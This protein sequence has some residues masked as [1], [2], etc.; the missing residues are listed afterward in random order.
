MATATLSNGLRI[1]FEPSTS[2][3]T[4]CGYLV[5]AGTRHEESADAGMAHFLEHMTFKGTARRTSLQINNFLERVGG[6]LNAFTNKQETVYHATVLRRD[7][8]RAIALLTDIVFHSTYPQSEITR[9]VEVIVDEIDS[10]RD[11]PAELIFDE[12]EQM[13]FA[14]HPLG[15]DILGTPERLRQYTTADATRFAHRFYRPDN[16]IFYIYGQVDFAR[17][18]RLLQKAHGATLVSQADMPDGDSFVRTPHLGEIQPLAAPT[19]LHRVVEKGT[20]Q[21]HVML[22]ARTFGSNDPR[23]FAL[24]L[25]NNML[26]GPGANSRLNTVVRERHG[27]VY[28]IDS[29]LNAYPDFGYWNAYFGCDAADVARCLRLVK[30]EL[31]RFVE[32][33]LS[34]AQ[35]RA[36]KAQLC[37]QIGISSDN[38]ESYA[39]GL[40]KTFAHFG[41]H[42]NISALLEAFN[43]VT[44]EEIQQL[45]AE[46]YDPE[47]LCT[48]IYK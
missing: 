37:G 19:A 24:S 40:G 8:A 15:R 23:R 7:V 38:K 21:A 12:F 9:E 34:A 32:R 11:S 33:P 26:G 36:A 5:C 20:H 29:Y 41:T 46:I 3:V 18:L 30:R 28:S 4:Y 1:I 6:D 25:L 35:L 39:M 22:G 31:L 43:A 42:R 10:Y 17:V 27:L 44:A 45:A 47:R 13:L 16:C 2:E 48:L 14:D